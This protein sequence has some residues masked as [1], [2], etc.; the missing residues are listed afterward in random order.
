MLCGTG[1]S[2]QTDWYG[3][4]AL[5]VFVFN[6]LYNFTHSLIHS[7]TGS[8]VYDNHPTTTGLQVTIDDFN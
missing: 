7:L 1:F 4:N 6:A 2:S 3:Y 5:D 8:T